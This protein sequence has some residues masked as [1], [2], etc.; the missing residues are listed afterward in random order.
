M[1]RF[2]ELRRRDHDFVGIIAINIHV[3]VISQERSCTHAEASVLRYKNGPPKSRC[4]YTD[5]KPRRSEEIHVQEPM[6]ADP[7]I[8][9]HARAHPRCTAQ[10]I[11]DFSVPAQSLSE[12]AGGACGGNEACP[13]GYDRTLHPGRCGRS[14]QA[15][16]FSVSRGITGKAGIIQ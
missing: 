8:P 12:T 14:G 4:I 13:R 2:P 7:Q 15:S 6:E 5:R 1:I 10:D 11:S 16:A 3:Q 9:T